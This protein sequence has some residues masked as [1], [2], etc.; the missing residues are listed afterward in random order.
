M[1]LPRCHNSRPRHTATFSLRETESL[2]VTEIASEF[3]GYKKLGS[4]QSGKRLE[5]D[6]KGLQFLA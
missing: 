6:L 2:K 5:R 1:P 3:P 4:L